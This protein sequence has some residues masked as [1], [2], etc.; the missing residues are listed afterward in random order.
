[1]VTATLGPPGGAISNPEGM[2]AHAKNSTA[3]VKYRK[4]SEPSC[5]YAFAERNATTIEARKM[6]TTFNM[7]KRKGGSK[8]VLISKIWSVPTVNMKA[9]TGI[10]A[11]CL[12][13]LATTIL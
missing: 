13:K 6:N 9:T 4:T 12:I 3:Q 1:M 2:T 7:K 8:S 11:I 10:A 5:K